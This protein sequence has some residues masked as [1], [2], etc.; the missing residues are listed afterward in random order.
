MGRISDKVNAL[1]AEI[2]RASAAEATRLIRRC[3]YLRR[4]S[5]LLDVAVVLASLGGC[6]IGFAVLTLFVGALRDVATASILFALF[7]VALICTV[8]AIGAFMAEI[9]MAGRGLRD[10]VDRQQDEA[11]TPR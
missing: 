1:S 7:G 5:L 6:L 11:F 4:R 9:L 3:S 8:A 10:K 2:D